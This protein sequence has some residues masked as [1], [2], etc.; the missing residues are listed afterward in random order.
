M[1]KRHDLTGQ[2]FGRLTAKTYF[3]NDLNPK[4]SHWICE[5]DC[6]KL[7]FVNVTNLKRGSSKS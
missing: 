2:R 3:K 6:G 5:C 4:K 1:T 7:A